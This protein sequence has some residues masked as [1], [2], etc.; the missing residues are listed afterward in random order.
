M[1]LVWGVNN[2][3]IICILF[4]PESGVFGVWCVVGVFGVWCVRA[5]V[6]EFAS[7]L[8]GSP[9]GGRS[10][11]LLSRSERSSLGGLGGLAPQQPAA[12]KPG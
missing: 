2:N 7:R 10:E 12:Q 3:Y 1:S 5:S 4:F 8:F 9:L 11:G 6:D